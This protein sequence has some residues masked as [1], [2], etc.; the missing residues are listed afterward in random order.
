[1]YRLLS[2]SKDTYITNKYISGESVVTSNVG[3]AGTMDLFKL[4]DETIVPGVTSSVVELSHGLI[5]FDYTDLV[6]ANPL[7]SFGDATFKCLL[8]L[9]SVYGGQTTP[10]NFVIE[11]LPL[12][13]SFAEGRGSDVIAYRDLDVCNYLSSSYGTSWVM[14][15]ASATGS[16][17]DTCDVIVSGNLQDGLGFRY[18]GATQNFLRGDEDLSVDITH[19]VSASLAGILDNNGL[20]ISFSEALEQDTNTYFVKRFG[21]RQA[22]TRAL[23]PR[24]IV[25][26]SSDIL[27]DSSGYPQLNV[28]QSLFVYNRVNDSYANFFSGSVQITGSDC[29]VLKLEASKS[30]DYITSSFSITHNATINHVTKSIAMWTDTFQANQLTSSNGVGISGIYKSD[31]FVSTFDQSLRDYLSGSNSVEMKISWVSL[32]DQ[33]VFASNYATFTNPQGSFSNLH[34]RNIV[35]NIVNLSTLYKKNFTKPSRLRVFAQD[36]NITNDPSRMPKTTLPQIFPNMFWRL[37]EAFTKKVIIPF[38]EAT[39]LSY[40]S[41]GMYFDVWMSDLDIGEIYQIDL[42]IGSI[43]GSSEQ[44]L[45]ENNGFR[46]KVVD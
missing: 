32:D 19:I 18:I 33:V 11:V 46:F 45:I 13:N 36:Y 31:C 42:S 28:S 3:Q 39:R 8:N 16:L 30:Y 38:D 24:L 5:H 7:L 43:D 23:Q 41:Q 21:T 25:K 14:S 10:S 29:L 44:T 22:Y 15:G 6:S 4:Y 2:A 27:Q 20:R 35:T 40:D 1:M 17:G 34:Q 26:T 9:K 37:K 12:S